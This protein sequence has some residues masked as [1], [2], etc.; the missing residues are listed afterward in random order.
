MNDVDAYLQPCHLEGFFAVSVCH[1]LPDKH[2]R[3]GAVSLGDQ[4]RLLK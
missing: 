2:E 4:V 3:S 1:F